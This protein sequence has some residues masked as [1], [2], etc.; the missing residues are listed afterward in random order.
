MQ[1]RNQQGIKK[2]VVAVV[3]IVYCIG[4]VYADIMFYQIVS[5][6]FPNGFFG[7]MATIGAFIAGATAILLPIAKVYWFAPGEQ[8]IVGVIF[9]V[10]DLAMMGLNTM[11][12]FQMLEGGKIDGFLLTWKEVCPMTPLICVGLWGLIFSLDP[13]NK[14]RHA[15]VGLQTT[16]IEQIAAAMERAARSQNVSG[17]VD[18]AGFQSA[19]YHAQQLSNQNIPLIGGP[20]PT[21]QPPQ[22]VSASL[23][24]TAQP[25]LI[26]MQQQPARTGL[27]QGLKNLFKGDETPVQQVAPL[28]GLSPDDIAAFRAWQAQQTPSPL[29]QPLPENDQADQ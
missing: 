10:I 13:A 17:I 9:Y 21:Q 23:A 16:Q 7:T 27:I 6:T 22:I 28:Q 5:R 12:A 18:A 29:S 11:L 8:E 20:T 2:V 15:Q 3:A 26:A 4:V 14:L 24:Q 25:S 1:S 19:L